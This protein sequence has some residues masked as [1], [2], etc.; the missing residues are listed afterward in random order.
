MLANASYG[1]MLD[2][3]FRHDING[4]LNASFNYKRDAFGIDCAIR[5]RNTTIECCDALRIIQKCDSPETFFYCDPP[6]VGADQGHYDGY[7]QDDFDRLLD[8]LSGLRGK[9]ILSSYR[10]T[11][12]TACIKKYKWESVEIK[13]SLTMAARYMAQKRKVEVLTA[14]YPIKDTAKFE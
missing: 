2:G 1:A 10:N 3:A 7:S 8:V 5:L 6:Y 4:K 13:M 9:F 11:A 14:N 12:L